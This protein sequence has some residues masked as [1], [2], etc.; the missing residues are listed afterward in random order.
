MLSVHNVKVKS[1]AQPN[2]TGERTSD[3]PPKKKSKPLTE[4]FSNL[5]R[6]DK[7]FM[8]QLARP[9]ASN[10]V[11]FNVIYSLTD[12]LAADCNGI[13]KSPNLSKH[14]SKSCD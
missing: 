12:L 6:E 2:I 3:K 5:E 4:Y 1:P 9:T 10:R 11:S 7:H 14:N 8:L 13:Q